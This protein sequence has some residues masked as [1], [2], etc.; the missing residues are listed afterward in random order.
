MAAFFVILMYNFI[1]MRFIFL[2]IILVV[3]L[4]ACNQQSADKKNSKI[5][6][7]F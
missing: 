2:S 7:P 6:N 4:A 3:F 1:A 5:N